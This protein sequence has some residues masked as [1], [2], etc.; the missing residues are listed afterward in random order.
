MKLMSTTDEVLD[1]VY[2]VSYVVFERQWNFRGRE[3]TDVVFRDGLSRCT[4]S[5]VTKQ[6]VFAYCS[7]ESDE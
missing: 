3:K 2:E 6:G 1:M 4:I 5:R 7:D